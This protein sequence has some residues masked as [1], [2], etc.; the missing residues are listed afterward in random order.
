M[1]DIAKAPYVHSSDLSDALE[2]MRISPGS[3]L[4]RPSSRGEDC[5]AI[6]V[7]MGNEQV[8]KFLIREAHDQNGG[9]ILAGRRFKSIPHVID[10][11]FLKYH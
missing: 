6:L 5:W 2:Q 3:F 8:K 7:N 4:L 11:F 9:W 10:R 1:D